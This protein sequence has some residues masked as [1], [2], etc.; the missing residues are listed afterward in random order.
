MCPRKA[1]VWLRWL[2]I[3]DPRFPKALSRRAL[4]HDPEVDREWRNSGGC[5]EHAREVL[6]VTLTREDRMP[7]SEAQVDVCGWAH[8]WGA[9][10]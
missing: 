1:A 9:A 2:Q 3:T 6:R 4:A 10:A 7:D 8:I 5:V